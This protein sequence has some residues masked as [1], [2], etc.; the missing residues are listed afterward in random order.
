MKDMDLE[1][2]KTIKDVLCKA[3]PDLREHLLVDD[4]FLVD[5]VA[6]E[7]LSDDDKEKIQSLSV[8]P[9]KVDTLL[10]IIKSRPQLAFFPFMSCLKKSD[11]V[12]HKEILKLNPPGI[13]K[14]T[15]SY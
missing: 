14:T 4:T 9:K 5:L 6:A 8:K 11:Q 7:V 13:Y 15:F 3:A 12:L 10:D 1:S 2:R